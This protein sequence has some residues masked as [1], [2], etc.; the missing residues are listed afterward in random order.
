VTGGRGLGLVGQGKQNSKSVLLRIHVFGS[1]GRGMVICSLS[2]SN[3]Q[4]I[5]MKILDSVIIDN[6]CFLAS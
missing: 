3:Q 2:S 5:T 1:E 4:S 6:N